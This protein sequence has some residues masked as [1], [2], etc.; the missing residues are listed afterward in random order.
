MHD[1]QY[2]GYREYK[3]PFTKRKLIFDPLRRWF[4]ASSILDF[5]HNK[6]ELDEFSLENKKYN[7]DILFSN[8][9]LTTRDNQTLMWD[10]SGTELIEESS[11][12]HI[13]RIG[14]YSMLTGMNDPNKIESYISDGKKSDI[15]VQYRIGKPLRFLCA[16]KFGQPQSSREKDFSE[17]ELVSVVN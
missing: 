2:Y 12:I 17:L 7:I 4:A 3:L 1:P 11:N 10:F 6:S 16:S 5:Q 8:I 15:A 13:L 9:V 14:I